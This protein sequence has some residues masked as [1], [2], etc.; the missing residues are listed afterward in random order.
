MKRDAKIKAPTLATCS[1]CEKPIVGITLRPNTKDIITPLAR[2]ARA[3]SPYF[4]LIVESG[5]AR[6]DRAI[7]SARR[8]EGKVDSTIQTI[9]RKTDET[10]KSVERE[11]NKTIESIES[12]IHSTTQTV[13]SELGA[14]VSTMALR[15]ILPRAL[16]LLSLGGDGTLI[17]TIRRSYASL[18]VLGVNIGNL[19][20]L[21]TITLDEI[22]DFA[23][24]LA[25]QNYI[26][27]KRS[28]IEMHL[29]EQAY[30]S[31]DEGQGSKA[32]T[33]LAHADNKEDR[34]DKEA[35]ERHIPLGRL[36]HKCLIVNEAHISK[37]AAIGT[38]T[39]LTR[40]GDMMINS[41]VCDGL[42]IA[43]PTGSTAY[44]VS[45]GGS[46]VHPH[47]SNILLTPVAP[48]S[49]TQR[50]LILPDN[51]ALSFCVKEEARIIADGQ[52]ILDFRAGEL[53]RIVPYGK[54]ARLI[55]RRGYSIFATLREKFSWGDA[56]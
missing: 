4:T 34:G 22:E 2:I 47:C 9:E 48:H 42:I 18:P 23:Y 27:E 28:L 41:I 13:E 43:T 32:D 7:Q 1:G 24:D 38:V 50:P 10:T 3:L 33:S 5:D 53:L 14:L 49:L 54:K 15:D 56:C 37:L 16:L 20:F 55:K 52:E 26:I 36:R 44:S 25:N 29:H 35:C 17:S 39:V 46:I 21:T 12:K 6:V 30:K 11:V 45:A 40:V 51:L 31:T 19:G 8:V